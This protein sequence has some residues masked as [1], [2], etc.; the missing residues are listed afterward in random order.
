MMKDINSMDREELIELVNNL[1]TER[2][3]RLGAINKVSVCDVEVES[4]VESL[5]KCKLIVND[6]INTNQKFIT[7]RRDKLK[8][9][10]LGYFG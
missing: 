6:L 8:L 7:L 1:I 10:S 3:F 9:D 4:N 2:A 5:D